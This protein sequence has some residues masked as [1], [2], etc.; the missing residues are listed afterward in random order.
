MID[1]AT[2][3]S[4]K[5]TRLILFP[6]FPLPLEHLSVELKLLAL[7]NVPVTATDLARP[8]RD[9]SEQ[10]AAGKS[11]VKRRVQGARLL[12]QFE[13]GQDASRLLDFLLA[14]CRA[15]LALLD[16]DLDAI[17]LLVP[18][19]ERNG[20]NLDNGVLHERLGAN[21]LVVGSVV[22][23]INNA[24]LPRDNCW[25]GE[26]RWGTS[27]L[28]IFFVVPVNCARALQL[29]WHE[30][31]D[32]HEKLPVSRRSARSLMLPPRTRRS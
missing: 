24:S 27:E 19:P 2:D 23:N 21:Q 5:V 6:L 14:L 32:P 30:P 29:I 16:A 18:L 11:L 8:G 1:W 4:L 10:T 25:W 22:P 17:V 15:L 28:K 26:G 31:S 12:P 3:F 7:E 9:A 13:L 20:I